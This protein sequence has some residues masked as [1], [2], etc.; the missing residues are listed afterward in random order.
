MLDQTILQVQLVYCNNFVKN[1]CFTGLCDISCINECM[2]LLHLDLGNNNLSCLD[3]L[4][5][6]KY[7]RIFRLCK[8]IFRSSSTSLLSSY[9]SSV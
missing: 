2:G 4:S 1:K 3:P 6:L 8:T 9:F 5:K 7:P